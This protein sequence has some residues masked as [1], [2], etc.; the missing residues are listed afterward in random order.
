MEGVA[1]VDF[2][3]DR[4]KGDLQIHLEAKGPGQ[5]MRKLYEVRFLWT[6]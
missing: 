3:G 2:K 5:Y 4:L 1:P 6:V